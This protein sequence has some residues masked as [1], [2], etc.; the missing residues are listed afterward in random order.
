MPELKG[1]RAL[2]TG[3]SAGIGATFASKLAERGYDL[4]LVARRQ[5]KLEKVCREITKQYDITCE[6][7][8]ADLADNGDIRR[9]ADRIRETPGLTMLV[10]NAGFGTHGTIAEGDFKRQ[11]DMITVHILATVTLCRAALPAMLANGRGD[12]I[13]VSSVSGFLRA[14]GSVTYCSTK[15][16]L[17][18]FSE[19]L[20]H[21]VSLSGLRVQALCPGFTVTEFHDTEELSDFDRN[22]VPKKWW[23][24][25]EYVVDKSLKALE[26]GKFLCIPSLRYWLISYIFRCPLL[27]A[28]VR[29]LFARKRRKEM[30]KTK[31]KI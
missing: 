22:S 23:M 8:Q 14:P 16:Y 12:I 27:T 30:E 2:I 5:E 20:H 29:P 3:A 21:E 28:L 26:K 25:A 6:I 31:E 1:N 7:Q 9:V 17:N 24:S 18:T 15:A 19:A 11:I 13:N 4:I 10:N